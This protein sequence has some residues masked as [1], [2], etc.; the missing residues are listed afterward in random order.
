M[1]RSSRTSRSRSNGHLTQRA[2]GYLHGGVDRMAAQGERLER[3]LHDGYETLDTQ[4]HRLDAGVRDTIGAHPWMAVGGSAM[5][6]FLFGLLSG[7]R[8]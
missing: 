3:R 7:R 6:G 1:A 8:T 5:L 4:A 2:A